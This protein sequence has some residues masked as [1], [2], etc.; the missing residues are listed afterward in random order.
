MVRIDFVQDLY[1]N[2]CCRHVFR[3]MMILIIMPLFDDNEE[4]LTHRDVSST[5]L[6]PFLEEFLNK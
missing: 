4:T 6:E 2:N 3:L 1:D 5:T